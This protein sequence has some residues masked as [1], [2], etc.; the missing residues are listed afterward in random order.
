MVDGLVGPVVRTSCRS[1][2]CGGRPTPYC[3]VVLQSLL[4]GEVLCSNRR[5]DVDN[6]S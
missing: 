2:D 3:T 5:I 1:A 6:A 4:V